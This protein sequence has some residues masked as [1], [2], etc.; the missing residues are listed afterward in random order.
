MKFGYGLSLVEGECLGGRDQ[1]K[2]RVESR[3]SKWIKHDVYCQG[4]VFENLIQLDDVYSFSVF[5]S[6]ISIDKTR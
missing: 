6:Q 5:G 1:T 2:W 3:L 4:G